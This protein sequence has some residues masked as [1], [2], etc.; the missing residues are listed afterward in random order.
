MASPQLPSM[1]EGPP[2]RGTRVPRC[3]Y[4]GGALH[5]RRRYHKG[6][7]LPQ[8][9]Q[10]VQPFRC[11]PPGT[12]APAHLL[13]RFY[14]TIATIIGQSCPFGFPLLASDPTASGPPPD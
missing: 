14:R 2:P 1:R 4:R 7:C 11:T 13:R 3:L 12:P 8:A 9:C 10:L 5:N 6:V